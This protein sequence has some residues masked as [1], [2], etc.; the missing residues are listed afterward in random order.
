VTRDDSEWQGNRRS[1]RSDVTKSEFNPELYDNIAPGYYDYVYRRG[2]GVQWFWHLRRFQRVLDYLPS[3]AKRLLDIGCGPGT[4]LGQFSDRYE[5]AVGIDIAEGQVAHARR[6]YSDV[7][8]EFRVAD[9]RD[10]T[11]AGEQFDAVVSIEVIEHLPMSDVQPFLALVRSVLRPGGTVVFTTPNY[12]SF[13]PIIEWLISV[14][15]HV[16]YRVQHLTHFNP[17]MLRRELKHAGFEIERLST[18]FIVS[19]F[20][21]GVSPRL[22]RF[23]GRMEEFVLPLLGSEIA[24]KAV[25][26]SGESA[27]GDG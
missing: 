24:V 11:A 7:G 9:L 21:A 26:P 15:G 27:R 22:A 3:T 23:I 14:R 20:L 1:G 6:N 12:H 13:W 10:L 17:S 19:P 25:R 4:F 2:R 5:R 8:A 16:D 18:F